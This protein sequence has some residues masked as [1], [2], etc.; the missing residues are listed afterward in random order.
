MSYPTFPNAGRRGGDTCPGC[1]EERLRL[2]RNT[3]T[4]GRFLGCPVCP[5]RCGPNTALAREI[6]EAKLSFEQI[7]HLRFEARLAAEDELA[8]STRVAD[9]RTLPGD[10][11]EAP[12]EPYTLW[13]A[14]RD[15]SL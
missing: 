4:R 1:V 6:Q 3:E 9:T 10:R 13:H 2:Y 14:M 15:G 8:Q 5:F 7:D 12:D 11:D